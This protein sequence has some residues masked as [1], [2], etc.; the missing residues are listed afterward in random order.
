MAW[1]TQQRICAWCGK[2]FTPKS[3]KQKCCDVACQLHYKDKKIRE[4]AKRDKLA[5]KEKKNV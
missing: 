5:R 1:N 3:P 2:L 4:K